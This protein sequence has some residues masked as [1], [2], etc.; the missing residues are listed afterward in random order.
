VFPELTIDILQKVISDNLW[1]CPAIER[2]GIV[3]SYARGQ[4]NKGSDV[5][6]VIDADDSKFREILSAFGMRVS[7]ILDYRFNKHLEI[8][9]YSL[10]TKRAKEKPESDCNWYY[11]EGYRQMLE[12]VKWIY[13]RPSDFGENK[14]LSGACTEVL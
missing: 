3:G 2:V 14:K 6:L 11:Q 5:D 4:Q 9:R 12:E 7:D 10:V 1:V 13:E 8:V